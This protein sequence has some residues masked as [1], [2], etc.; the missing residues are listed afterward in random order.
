M[1]K[2]GTT[3]LFI[4]FL[5]FLYSGCSKSEKVLLVTGGHAYDTLEFFEVFNQM[6]GID[7]E[8]ISHPRATSLLTS[9]QV[10]QFDLLVFYDFLPDIP[11]RDSNIFLHLTQKGKPML[12]LHHSICSFQGWDGYK[13][14]VGGRYV[15]PGFQVD[16]TLLSGYKHDIDMVIEVVDT[17]H[18]ITRGMNDFRIHDEG[19]TNITVLNEVT[20]LLRTEHPD[21]DPLVGWVNTFHNSTV[22]YLMLG[23]D[24]HAYQNPFFQQLVSNSIFWLTEKD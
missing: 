10:D 6:A 11:A 19:Y 9:D 4:F 15:M 14:M 20:P 23:H 22:V 8:Y 7:F 2:S 17:N 21:C 12:F 24:K 16:T 5:T 18:P 13:K 1:K 3:L